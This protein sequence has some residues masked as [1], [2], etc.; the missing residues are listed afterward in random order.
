MKVTKAFKV[1][2]EVPEGVSVRE[3]QEYIRDSVQS[4]KGCFRPGCD[5]FNLNPDKVTCTPI[6]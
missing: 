4:W 1:K 5:L 2:V 3:M 6:R